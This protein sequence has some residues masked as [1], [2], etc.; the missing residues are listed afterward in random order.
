M[1]VSHFIAFVSANGISNLSIDCCVLHDKSLS[2]ECY[3]CCAKLLYFDLWF[4]A[5]PRRIPS[6]APFFWRP[7]IPSS[8]PRRFYYDAIALSAFFVC[9]I[10]ASCRTHAVAFSLSSYRSFAHALLL[11]W[12]LYT[13]LLVGFQAKLSPSRPPTC[14]GKMSIYIVKHE[15]M[16]KKNASPGVIKNSCNFFKKLDTVIDITLHLKLE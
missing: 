9:L 10:S 13:T 14:C 4:I 11:F 15:E 12:Y 16:F 6:T 7:R 3:G 1:L 8:R 5:H 2:L